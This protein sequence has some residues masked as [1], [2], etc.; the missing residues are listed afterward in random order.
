MSD[1]QVQA[2]GASAA[3][4]ADDSFTTLPMRSEPPATPTP[5]GEISLSR[6]QVSGRFVFPALNQ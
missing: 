1:A 2:P 6:G 4:M 3:H 5:S